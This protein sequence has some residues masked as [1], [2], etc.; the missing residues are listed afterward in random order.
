V[1]VP[2]EGEHPY[3]ECPHGGFRS[4]DHSLYWLANGESITGD[5]FDLAAFEP[6][7]AP[8]ADIAPAGD[9]VTQ[10]VNAVVEHIANQWEGCMYDT[11]MLAARFATPA[12]PSCAFSRRRKEPAMAV[13]LTQEAVKH[14]AETAPVFPYGS[15][16]LKAI[17]AKRDERGRYTEYQVY[18]VHHPAVNGG[19]EHWT[20]NITY[21]GQVVPAMHDIVM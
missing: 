5:R 12:K 15:E 2:P 8:A 9:V 17:H 10:T 7:P 20:L 18:V 16:E 1:Y 19:A 21:I 13:T 3:D 14:M 11:W 4:K 6:A